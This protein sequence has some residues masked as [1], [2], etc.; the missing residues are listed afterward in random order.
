MS[1]TARSLQ[2]HIQE[3]NVVAAVSAARYRVT[4]V[5]LE[6]VPSPS[7]NSVWTVRVLAVRGHRYLISGQLS[8]REQ[9]ICEFSDWGG[10]WE[11][12]KH[13]WLEQL[14]NDN[15]PPDEWISG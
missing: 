11:D 1:I 2:V 13:A 6:Y 9:L 15:W 14:I 8:K 12:T 5:D 7:P 4:A 10:N 3:V